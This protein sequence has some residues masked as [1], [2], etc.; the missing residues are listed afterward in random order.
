MKTIQVKSHKR[1]GKVVKSHMRKSN[2][3]LSP[4]GPSAKTP[5][6]EML[7]YFK[8]SMIRSITNSDIRQAMYDYNN[9]DAVSASFLKREGYLDKNGFVK[10]SAF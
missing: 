2:N 3:R 8:D 6:K 7:T 5:Q 10:E 4:K 9:G 1:K